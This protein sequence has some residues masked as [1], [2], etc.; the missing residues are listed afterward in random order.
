MHNLSLL[1]LVQKLK[2]KEITS[3]FLVNYFLTRIKKFDH[4]LNSFVTINFSSLQDA[5][6]IDY[7]LS[8]K[9]E[10]FSFF[11]G[12]P[13]AQKDN[14]CTKGLRTTCG[15]R[16][17]NFFVP[18]YDSDI[19]L[20]LKKNNFILLGKTNMDEFSM[21]SSGETSFFGPVRNPWK[22]SK[23]PGGSSSGSAAAVAARFVPFAI[24]SDTGGSVRQPAA[25][26]GLVGFKPTYGLFSRYG[27]ISFSSSLDQMGI[28]SKTVEDCFFV[29]NAL[30]SSITNTD[31]TECCKFTFLTKY[32]YFFSKIIIGVLD[33]SCF[34][35]VSNDVVRLYDSTIICL[36]QMGFTITEIKIPSFFLSL[37]AYYIFSSIEAS[38]NLLRFDGFRY[39]C[40]DFIFKKKKNDFFFNFRDFFFGLE[41]RRRLILGTSL[42]L[43]N[44][45]NVD[46]YSNAKL[47]QSKVI[48]DCVDL[49][50]KIHLMLVP[51]TA[52]SAF[53]LNEKFNDPLA[54]YL[55]DVFT[56]FVSL[57][58]LPAISVPVGFSADGLPI[59]VQFIANYYQ[60]DLL[61]A[62]THK[63]QLKT[64]W[65]KSIPYYFQ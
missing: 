56:T 11:F 37:P 39:G 62:V 21:G 49:F 55:T 32:T 33:D 30:Q 41:V 43:Q 28:L 50:K 9:K 31:L 19:T 20:K 58:G 16:V 22:L 53:N 29:F 35:G 60:E 14:F 12:I 36:Q 45:R 57:A 27:L 65:H 13:F 23:V 52:S 18:S 63:Y 47:I 24:G 61:F 44:K 59:G 64:D 38:S 17:L 2:K 8:K 25:F 40:N 46:F 51:T 48:G 54:M 1:N 3:Y 34:D 5:K 42:L 4:L 7:I 15:S 10:D 6:L 26:C